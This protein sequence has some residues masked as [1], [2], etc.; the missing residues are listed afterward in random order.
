MQ[1]LE[2]RCRELA[3]FD[4]FSDG[5]LA[6]LLERSRWFSLPGG[7]QLF[8]QGDEPDG[9]YFVMSGR[10]I[11]VRRDTFGDEVVGYV[12]A[13]DPVGEMSLLAGEPRSA[14]AYALRDTEVIAVDKAEAEW[15]LDN[16]ADFSHALAKSIVSRARHPASSFL[17]ARPRVFALI[18]S[19]PSIDIEQR[20]KALA[21]VIERYGKKTALIEAP[22]RL[23]DGEFEDIECAHDVTLLTARVGDSFDYRFA[24]R[25]A[26]RFL[27]FARQD[28]RPPRPFPLTLTEES[29]AR[30]FRLVDVA[31][32]HE[33]AKSGSVAD[34]VDAVDAHR[35]FH[36]TG[37]RSTERLARALAGCS[38][39]VVMSG[40]GA[41][42][43]AHIGAIK[44]LRE[45]RVPIDFLGG[46]SMG[47]VVAACVAM[48]WND[49]EIETRVRDAFVSSNPLG[50]HILPVVALTQGH[51]VEERLKRHFGDTLIEDL[52][53]PFFCT[54]SEL[55]RGVTRIHRRGLLRDALRASIS[56]PGILPPVVADGELLVDGAIMNNFPTDH[57][58]SLHRGVTIGVDVAREGTIALQAFVDPPGFLSWVWQH[59]FRSAPPIV[60]LLMRAATSR[61]ETRPKESPVDI[62][63]TPPVAGVQLRD[64]KAYD[65]AV[66]DG[67]AATL[68]TLDRNWTK[69]AAIVEAGLSDQG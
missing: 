23:A 15:L 35:V 3:S 47:A 32:L 66:I 60:S 39:G 55:T 37:S 11:V 10:L 30:K 14:S 59:G 44:A 41:R 29:P 40:G 68:G 12:R 42:A 22:D 6:M 50:D 45:R 34:W 16:C 1:T 43:Y 69:I 46:A 36:V 31:M 27:V 13:G 8:Q 25:H 5:S 52:E 56:L 7:S 49:D 33:G 63:V 20:A 17:R 54:S 48:G 67:Y 24:L 26:D 28:A 65:L 53:T 18:G 2:E 38:V 19:S 51:R 21:R 62:L 9:V 57:M 4:L 61:P 58:N 64:W